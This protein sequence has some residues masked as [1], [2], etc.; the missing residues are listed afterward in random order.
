MGTMQ[1]VRIHDFGG[2]EVLQLER[3]ERPEPNA[4]EALIEGSAKW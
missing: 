2:P 1:V 3:V 4:D